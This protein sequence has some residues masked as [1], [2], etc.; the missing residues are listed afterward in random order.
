LTTT[1]NRSCPVKAAGWVS[2]YRKPGTIGLLICADLLIGKDRQVTLS[3]LC[4]G[5]PNTVL[6]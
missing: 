5:A 1:P 3:D 4:H 6:L 2:L